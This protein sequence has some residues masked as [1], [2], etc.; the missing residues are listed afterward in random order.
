MVSPRGA[1]ITF[2]TGG[3]QL[4]NQSAP[5]VGWNWVTGE[6][7]GYTYWY[8]SEPNDNAG[9]TPGVEDNEENFAAFVPEA[10]WYDYGGGYAPKYMVEYETAGP[11]VPEPSTLLLLGLGLF[12]TGFFKRRRK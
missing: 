6:P 2:F 3:Y 12:G 8:S 5:N 10:K 4:S 7:W 9:S 11:V 1:D